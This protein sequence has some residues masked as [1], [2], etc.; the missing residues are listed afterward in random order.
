MPSSRQFL[1]LVQTSTETLL[2]LIDDILD[3]SKIDAGKL[4]LA[5]ISYSLRVSLGVCLKMLAVRAHAKGLEL[6]YRVADDAP[7]RVFGDVGRLRQCLLNLVGNSIKFTERGEIEVQTAIEA[8]AESRVCLRFS[9]RD[10]GIGIPADKIDRVFAPF[11]QADA[12]TTRKFGGT[13]LGLAIV[14]K[15]VQ[16]SWAAASGWIASRAGEARSISRSGWAKKAKNCRA[17]ANV[18]RSRA[19]GL[20]GLPALIVDDNATSR[21]IL[22]E[23]LRGWGMKP[24]TAI[25]GEEAIAELEHA[26]IVGEPYRLVLIDTRACR[27][28]T[29]RGVLQADSPE[30]RSSADEDLRAILLTSSDQPAGLRRR[31]SRCKEAADSRFRQT[32]QTIGI[33]GCAPADSRARAGSADAPGR[34]RRRASEVKRPAAA[35]LAGGG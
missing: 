11:E 24:A 6:V 10:T 7:D 32:R 34:K 1:S 4:E 28:K 9:V 17:R 15:L 27:A 13:G 18:C 25:N 33:A 19:P 26:S 5:P 21:A 12:S 35:N 8:H 14:T 22:S 20:R 23:L 16:A 2:T 30:P 29:A 31:S 3:F